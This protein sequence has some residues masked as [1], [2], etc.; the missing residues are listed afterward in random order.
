MSKAQKHKQTNEKASRVKAVA[1]EYEGWGDALSIQVEKY[2][3]G[4]GWGERIDGVSVE[5]AGAK[6][7][8]GWTVN[9]MVDFGGGHKTCLRQLF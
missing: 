6:A 8:A 2:T 7:E 3:P 9:F 1:E 5:E 4:K